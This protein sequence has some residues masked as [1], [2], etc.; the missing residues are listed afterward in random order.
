[1]S[2]KIEELI[3]QGVLTREDILKFAEMGAEPEEEEE[4]KKFP[5]L[6]LKSKKEKKFPPL[7][8]K[9]KKQ[10][11]KEERRRREEEE[12]VPRFEK[13]CEKDQGRE[14]GGGEEG[15]GGEEEGEG[16]EEEISTARE[17]D[18]C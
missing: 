17:K 12:E 4:K 15:E 14:E 18:H 2:S 3:K 13:I 10:E 9:A 11:E 5:P 1:M 6:K 7:K 8:L 16:G